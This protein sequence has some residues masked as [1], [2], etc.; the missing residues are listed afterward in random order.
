MVWS[1]IFLLVT[2]Q[3]TTSLRPIIGRSDDFLT[4]EKKFFLQHWGDTMGESLPAVPPES[5]DSS[6]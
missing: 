5:A 2:L 4:S 1:G 6:R 3:M